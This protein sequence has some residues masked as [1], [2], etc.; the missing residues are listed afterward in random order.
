MNL[1]PTLS[2]VALA[3]ATTQAT[4]LPPSLSQAASVPE[5]WRGQKADLKPLLQFAD[6]RRVTEAAQWPQRRAEILQQ[7]MELLGPWPALLEH[8]VLRQKERVPRNDGLLQIRVE[9]QIAP[10]RF[11]SGWLLQPDRQGPM[12]AVFV[13]FYEPETSIGTA[14]K[15]QRDFA[16]QLARRG[17]VT[18]SIGSPGGDAR[19]PLL[20]PECS[21]QPLSYLGYI[22]A[23]AWQA[24]ADLPQVDAKR[25]GIVGHSY[26][27]KWSMFGACLSQR[28]AAAVWSDP[29]IAFDESRAS[30]NYQEPW[31]L[32]LDAHI[33]RKPGLVR[34]DSP[35]TGAYKNLRQ[36]G[37]DLHE[38]QALMAPRPFLVSG[39]AEDPPKR[40]GL[41]NAVREVY[42]LLGADPQRVAM[43]NR[44]DHDPNP[45]S[46]QVIVDF[47][48]HWLS[49]K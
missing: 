44:P 4:D 31:Y 37:H 30:I 5:A 42:S 26:G 18:L 27:G 43:T 39:G 34:A 49:D 48:C 9:L 6:G 24:L 47:F 17:F 28:Y 46:N 23:N 20:C 36:R 13:P 10:Q 7:W 40:W 35:R 19:K 21:T 8:P 33:T 29:G 45:Q 32:G 15:P 14:G 25:I 2:L 22:S 16:L 3:I 1:L 38:V 41:L 12:P 11:E